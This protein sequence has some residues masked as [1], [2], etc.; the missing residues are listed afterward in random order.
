MLKIVEIWVLDRKNKEYKEKNG[1][2]KSVEIHIF[3]LLASFFLSRR[4]TIDPDIT[5]PHKVIKLT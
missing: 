2:D 3:L 5:S 4:G 1:Y